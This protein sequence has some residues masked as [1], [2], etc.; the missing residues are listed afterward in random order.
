[1]IYWIGDV[2]KIQNAIGAEYLEDWMKRRVK[3]GIATKVIRVP[4]GEIY[5]PSYTQE[6]P[7]LRK[8]KHTPDNFEAPSHIIIYGDNVAFITTKKEA[9]GTVITSREVAITMRS[10]WQEVWKNGEKFRKRS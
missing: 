10:C 6:K 4:V 3:K 9:F 5:T 7:V 1:M 8:I 2:K